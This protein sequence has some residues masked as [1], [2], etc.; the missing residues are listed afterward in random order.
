MIM[1]LAFRPYATAGVAVLGAGLIYITPVTAPRIEQRAV[2]LAAAEDIIDLVNPI[3]TGFS[4]L[5]GA[6]GSALASV[7]DALPSAATWN[8]SIPHSGN[9]SGFS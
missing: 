5:A 7:S 9:C 4:T 6:G 8:S 2:D 1:Q 3:D